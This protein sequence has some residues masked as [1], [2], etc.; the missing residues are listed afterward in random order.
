MQFKTFNKEKKMDVTPILIICLWI[1]LMILS[2]S[3][4]HARKR[5]LTQDRHL[6]DIV[7]G[8]ALREEFKE[9]IEAVD[10]IEA[11]HKI[12]EQKKEFDRKTG[13]KPLSQKDICKCCNVVKI[14]FCKCKT[15]QW[16]FIIKTL[17]N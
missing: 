2:I 17:P 13:T 10:E 4:Y 8:K 16:D 3:M 11:E 6:R 9:L 7:Q 14:P 1:P 15:C 12:M 5:V